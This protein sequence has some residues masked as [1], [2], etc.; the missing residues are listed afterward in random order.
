MKKWLAFV[1]G[2]ERKNKAFRETWRTG[3]TRLVWH[4]PLDFKHPGPTLMEANPQRS[5]RGST[6]PLR[7]TS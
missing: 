1:L 3:E 2:R 7:L 4:K 6:R 5:D